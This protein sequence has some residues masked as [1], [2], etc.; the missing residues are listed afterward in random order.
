MIASS[1]VAAEV[2]LRYCELQR[3]VVEH[4][5]KEF[6]P[7]DLERFADVERQGVLRVGDEAWQ[8]TRH[9]AGV[10]FQNRGVV[11]DAHVGMA[12]F[13]DALDGWRLVQYLESA[14]VATL[15]FEG[16]GVAADNEKALGYLL[17]EM[18]KIGLLE[19]VHLLPPTL[20]FRPRRS[21]ACA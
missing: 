7:K 1:Q 12:I 5:L 3:Q 13:P 2:V 18:V 21:V 6:R 20:L 10:L 19:E 11:I 17:A 9:G 15:S 16:K 8:Y 14:G 4:F